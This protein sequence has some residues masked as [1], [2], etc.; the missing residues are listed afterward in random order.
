MLADVLLLSLF[1]VIIG[2]ALAEIVLFIYRLGENLI[3]LIWRK[4]NE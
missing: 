3:N 1:S 4:E 2:I